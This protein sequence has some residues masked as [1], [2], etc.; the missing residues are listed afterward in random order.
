[1]SRNLLI[2]GILALLLIV[3]GTSTLH[4]QSVRA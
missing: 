4:A 2:K 1:M 3:A